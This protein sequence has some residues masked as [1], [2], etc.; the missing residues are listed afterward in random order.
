MASR[1]ELGLGLSVP[2]PPTAYTFPYTATGGVTVGSVVYLSGSL[3]L[4]LSDA[5]NPSTVPPLGIVSSVSGSNYSLSGP[6]QIAEGLTGLTPNAL[7]YLDPATPGAYTSVQPLVNPYIVGRALSATQMLVLTGSAG[8][9]VGLPGP[10]GST[11]PTGNLGPTGATGYMGLDGATGPTGAEGPTGYVGVDGATGD[12]GPTGYDGADGPTGPT[13]AIGPTG[14]DGTTGTTGPT[15]PSNLQ[16]AYEGGPTVTTTNALGNLS[17]VLDSATALIVTG[18]STPTVQIQN[19]GGTAG[20]LRLY[21]PSGSGSNFTAFRA[22]AQ[23]A[24]VTY[25]LPAAD[26]S[27]GQGLSTDGVGALS[28][29]SFALLASPTFTGTPAAPTPAATDNSTQIATTAFTAPMVR[30]I[31][32]AIGTSAAQSS[33]TTIPTGARPLSV[34]LQISTAYTAGAT[35]SI[36]YSGATSFLMATTDNLPGTLGIYS[37]DIIGSTWTSNAVLVT[38]GNTPAAGAGRVRVTYAISVST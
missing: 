20:Q 5:T 25:T 16:T 30:V 29:A 8:G 13:G 31:E 17:V 19:T 14:Y 22:Q 11:G 21:E 33:T 32:F 36:G 23:A 4:S 26:G 1:I 10:T 24:D 15:G 34:Q 2:A 9:S 7:Y 12:T 38:I 18:A 35:I 27:S 3:Q 37:L 6:S 28:W